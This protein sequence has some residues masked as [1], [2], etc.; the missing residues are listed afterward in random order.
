MFALRTSLLEGLEPVSEYSNAWKRE[1][2]A[3]YRD[4]RVV[5]EGIRF[6]DRATFDRGTVR[7]N[8]RDHP[9]AMGDRTI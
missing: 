4:H 3:L 7:E 5:N 2:G 8:D 9:A 1:L 6:V